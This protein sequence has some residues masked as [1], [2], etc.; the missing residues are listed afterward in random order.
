MATGG[1]DH[2]VDPLPQAAPS[3]PGVLAAVGPGGARRPAADG[4]GASAALAA[5][6]A[7]LLADP[8]LGSVRTASV[9]E[10]ATGRVL[11][12]ARPREAMT[13]AS[14]I[15]IATAAAAS[16][17]STASAPPWRRAPPPGRSSWSAAA[18]RP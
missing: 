17:P 16:A 10:A 11:Y 9:V 8:A 15:K 5:A 4:A 3:A 14:T 13:P 18:T 1:A 12:E 6:L 2:G 7:P